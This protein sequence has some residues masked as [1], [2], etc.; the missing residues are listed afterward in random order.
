MNHYW[1]FWLYMKSELASFFFYLCFRFRICSRIWGKTFLK[2]C[3]VM[4]YVPP[5]KNGKLIKL[6]GKVKK[7]EK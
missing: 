7:S 5:R 2:C 3:R 1:N 6:A 4:E